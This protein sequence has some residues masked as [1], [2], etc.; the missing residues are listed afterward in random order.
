[1]YVRVKY[2]KQSIVQNYIYMYYYGY[3]EY[4]GMSNCVIIISSIQLF[5]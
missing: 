3:I 5:H 2:T 1:M 4:T